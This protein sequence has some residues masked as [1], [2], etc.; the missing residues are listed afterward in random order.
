M[1]SP[2]TAPVLLKLLAENLQPTT[3]A[4]Y[5]ALILAAVLG[6][7]YLSRGSLWDK[8]DPYNYIYFERPQQQSGVAGSQTLVSRNIAQKLSESDKRAVIFW[9]SQSG[10]AERFANHL[11][12]EIQS[13]FGIG[14]LSADLSDYECD[15]IAD[16]TDKQLAL[17]VLSTYGEGD[18][19]DNANSFWEW[20]N[21]GTQQTLSKLQYAAFGL[22][23]SNYKY[24]NRVVDVTVANLN[25]N[26]AKQLLPAGK[27]DDAERSTDEDFLAWKDDLFS[28]FR[29]RLGLEEQ[30]VEY[31]PTI[32]V[33]EDESLEPID[34][35]H[36]E[37][38][39]SRDNPKAT[40]ACS[41][42]RA[43]SVTN[44]K[45][46]FHAS[47]RNCLHM[48]LDLSEH[49]EIYYKT[50]DHLAVWPSNPE[51]EVEILLSALQ[52]HDRKDVP[53]T[54]KSADASTKLQIPT[55]TTALALFHRYLEICAPV[56]RTTIQGLAAFAPTSEA[57]SHV[58]KL[59]RDRQLY[60]KFLKEN[61]LTFGR[62][63]QLASPKTPWTSLPLSYV[64][65]TLPLMQPRYYSISSSS[66]LNPRRATITALVAADPLPEN[67]EQKIN[68]VTS[69]YLLAL[70]QA[71]SS[72]R[73]PLT[74]TSALK[75][76]L[77]GSSSA[78]SGTKLFA[79]IR[80]SKFKLPIQAG[81]P[82]VMVAAGT[83]LA[84]FRAFI[85]E[86]TKLH[87]IG[88]P[89]GQMILFFGC[90][91]PEE[92]FIYKEEL[93]AAQNVV[94]ADGVERLKIITAFSRVE[95][96]LKVYVQQRVGEYGHELISL[97]EEK[98]A[99]FYICGR[100][101]MARE[102]GFSL[103]DI[104]KALRGSNDADVKSWSEGLKRTGKWK[105]DVWGFAEK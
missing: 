90:R 32:Y 79:H 17:F 81:T 28:M 77:L 7:A 53:L 59:G 24:Y 63:L 4:D 27:A 42:I 56:S 75:Y 50:G 26:G 83:G 95:G 1:A 38:T 34:L 36:G 67:S 23:N 74:E 12:K 40:A 91:R 9:G 31:Q 85:A 73:I 11:A 14:A 39:H 102:V 10:T 99:S 37:P 88:K 89:I 76:D 29:T 94:N 5:L 41:P 55:P 70:S 52:L 87:A 49:P 20:I 16:L 92:D 103:G 8:P 97:I 47:E 62:L 2:S 33:T 6:A 58:L 46:L 51:S 68:G 22:G 3:T 93:E 61:H 104:M 15:S 60:Q 25:K 13:R 78:L 64:I 21:K 101:S 72:S 84:P 71:H 65:E 57:K 66:V 69:N 86:R 18:P 45:E 35:H 44:P 54:F 100:A 30:V 80:R 105:E 96:Q 98:S 19:S 48:E 43:L 82:I